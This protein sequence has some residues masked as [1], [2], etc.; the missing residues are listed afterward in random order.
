MSMYECKANSFKLDIDYGY[1]IENEKE[2]QTQP[3]RLSLKHGKIYFLLFDYRM[4]TSTCNVPSGFSIT[5]LL[6]VFLR[7]SIAACE[8]FSEI[9]MLYRLLVAG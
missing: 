5:W 3:D 4:G 1:C 8:R 9:A 2:K 7:A 6:P